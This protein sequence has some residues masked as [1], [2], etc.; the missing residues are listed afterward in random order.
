MITCFAALALVAALAAAPATADT[1][2]SRDAGSD[3]ADCSQASPCRT[4]ERGVQAAS[5]G[6]TV[7]ITPAPSPYECPE[8]GHGV[9]VDKPLTLVGASGPASPSSAQRAVMDCSVGGGAP[10][11]AL[12]VNGTAASA[13]ASIMAVTVERLI[14]RNGAAHVGG[15][16]AAVDASLH[17]SDC[18]FA[19]SYATG[20]AAWAGDA[21]GGG[22]VFAAI[23]QPLE[24]VTLA[25]TRTAITD[26]TAVGCGGGLAV[27]LL[28][29][30]QQPAVTL[31]A[32]TFTRCTAQADGGQGARGGGA[33]VMVHAPAANAQVTATG[34]TFTR[35]EAQG[36]D[37]GAAGR[38]GGLHVEFTEDSDPDE[39][40]SA[41]AIT[42]RDGAFSHCT[43]T[44][45]GGVFVA[46]PPQAD[47]SSVLVQ[48]TLLEHCGGSEAGQ[49]SWGGGMYL[50]YASDGAMVEHTRAVV[51]HS[52]LRACQ[53]GG[54]VF[55]VSA[56]LATDAQL[57]VADTTF[58]DMTSV[59][60]AGV[61]A[62]VVGGSRLLS[63]QLLRC[64]FTRCVARDVGGG[65][66]YVRLGSAE[67][68]FVAA[69]DTQFRDC[70][71]SQGLG[72]GLA[73]VGSS[74]RRA[75][76][77]VTTAGR[78]FTADFTGSTFDNC[79]AGQGGG[80][81]ALAF[82]RAIECNVRVHRT[83]F[84]DCGAPAAAPNATGGG[85]LITSMSV[86]DGLSVNVTDSRFERCGGGM[87]NGGALG[88]SHSAS[89]AR[90]RL[91]IRDSV[92][93]E[94]TAT[95]GAAL[96]AYYIAAATDCDIAVHASRFLR[97]SA[98]EGGAL[99]LL[100]T[101]HA[102]HNDLQL[103]D[104]D[105]HACTASKAGGALAVEHALHTNS[106][107][108]SVVLRRCSVVNATA[109]MVGGGALFALLPEEA[110]VSLA[111]PGSCFQP[112]DEGSGA[113][114]RLLFDHQNRVAVLDSAILHSA[115][116]CGMCT[117]GALSV[118][119][120]IVEVNDTALL[121]CTAGGSGG[122][123]FT[124]GS[125]ALWLHRVRLEAEVPRR[126]TTGQLLHHS[127][128]GKLVLGA[129]SALLLRDED[130]E[131]AAHHVHVSQ[132]V[133]A[134]RASV[135]HMDSNATLHCPPGYQLTDDSL[136]MLL[137][138]RVQ[139]EPTRFQVEVGDNTATMG[140]VFLR[141]CLVA[142]DDARLICRQCPADTYTLQVA[143]MRGGA[144][145]EEVRCRPCPYG[146][147][148]SRGGNMVEVRYNFWG[149]LE[150]GTQL[151]TNF[152]P[153]PPGYC[154]PFATCPWEQPCN[155]RRAGPLCGECQPGYTE[156]FN[157]VACRPADKCG[158]QWQDVLFWPAGLLGVLAFV[159]YLLWQARQRKDP[160]LGLQRPVFFFY[161]TV[162]LL[163]LDDQ[164][165][166][167]MALAVAGAIFN[168]QPQTVAAGGDGTAS[169]DSAGVCPWVGLTAAG[170]EAFG[171]V[172][173]AAYAFTLVIGYVLHSVVFLTCCIPVRPPRPAQ[174]LAAM[175][176]LVLLCYA[177]LVKSTFQLLRCVTLPGDYGS[178]LWL[179]ASVPCSPWRWWQGVLLAIAFIVLCPMPFALWQGGKRLARGDMS[180]GRFLLACAAPAVFI[181]TE[182]AAYLRRRWAG[183][184]A[185][186]RADTHADR[187]AAGSTPAAAA[188]GLV[189]P[190]SP[191]ALSKPMSHS[192]LAAAGAAT[193]ATAS[194][195]RADSVARHASSVPPAAGV[196]PP[197]TT[198]NAVLA[199]LQGPF[200]LP[201]AQWEAVLIARRLIMLTVFVAADNAL[202][203][204]VAMTM[205]SVTFLAHEVWAQP[206]LARSTN[207]ISM[208]SLGVQVTL[209]SLNAVLSVHTV[210]GL[211]PQA[212]SPSDNISEAVKLVE[213][214]L[215]LLPGLLLP[216]FIALPRIL[217]SPVMRVLPEGARRSMSRLNSVR[218][219]IRAR[220]RSQ[221][222][223]EMQGNRVQGEEDGSGQTYMNPMTSQWA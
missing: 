96:G 85:L 175:M 111:A 186:R 48:G 92:F 140:G 129:G 72:G 208:F 41:P 9:L 29:A 126:G 4:V 73:V 18:A 44:R 32:T 132:P 38:G 171:L 103:T 136:G 195:E 147:S 207:V 177:A 67:H 198:T 11:R 34:S 193:P 37:N 66:A 53:G 104:C 55:N 84:R 197:Y 144:L 93:Q 183:H 181:V 220:S 176:G 133:V 1:F 82:F 134:E 14:V 80:G 8:H 100:Y 135:W 194:G 91:R 59:I 153:C 52:T 27:V 215:L 166:S 22:S 6:E 180:A 184:G 21:A 118:T 145:E 90:V 79:K 168:L 114:P 192:S 178:R 76:A 165:Q 120:G 156:A 97:C 46:L 179:M 205:V 109:G 163:L 35:C 206:Y 191:T 88:M 159:A 7:W 69:I 211:K 13:G 143:A 189:T 169:S 33:C 116:S 154:C 217:S 221:M 20:A 62:A 157:T 130:Q 155:G 124:A 89:A 75:N 107:A 112:E 125:A 162:E 202:S 26:S 201:Y 17:V 87:A 28:A 196:P 16:I 122:T 98:N 146:A 51:R 31:D 160:G 200:R 83:L 141:S 161:Q 158:G 190:A 174:Y 188:A 54:I 138:A 43:A 40:Y 24:G 58:T 115:A 63:L 23:T 119:N 81:A 209:A 39:G 65:L 203:R 94:C 127:G 185:P 57:V 86:A 2:V 108:N 99:F 49:E 30:T 199:V 219:R 149:G 106:S 172:T 74:L 142:T 50:H 216:L 77:S 123:V 3:A 25:L 148:C 212:G 213:G 223:V 64:T 105:L 36:A 187:A 102:Q 210:E 110:D 47:H 5:S 167:A 222:D 45:G 173:P 12:M 19:D 182:S 204:S 139:F 117:G 68:T 128:S 71:A 214:V 150:N 121:N 70:S 137:A 61:Y 170:K 164:K 101:G 56:L 60:G 218:E 151:A 113:P 95:R 152:V 78:N 42:V 15:A 10:R 131:G